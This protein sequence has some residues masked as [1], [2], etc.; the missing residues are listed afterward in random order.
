MCYSNNLK[1]IIGTIYNF[2]IFN[3]SKIS[4]SLNIH[5]LFTKH[6]SIGK[7]SILIC[8]SEN[9]KKQRVMR[10]RLV[11]R[12]TAGGELFDRDSYS[13]FVIKRYFT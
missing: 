6:I 10:S 12:P 2:D 7:N 3:K 9:R 8:L 4:D 11:M 5:H 13:M 1:L